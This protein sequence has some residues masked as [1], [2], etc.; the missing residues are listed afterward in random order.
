MIGSPSGQRLRTPATA[1]YVG[2]AI[3]TLEKMRCRGDGP[4]FIRIGPRAVV[5]D[6]RDLDA[7]L[8]ARRQNSTSE[9][10]SAPFAPAARRRL[11]RASSKARS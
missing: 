10:F 4:P 7:W 2:L 11:N 3:S 6:T 9:E 8:S 1:E 5:Y